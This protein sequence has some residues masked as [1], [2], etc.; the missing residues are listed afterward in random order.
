MRW[1]VEIAIITSS[2]HTTETSFAEQILSQLCQ[3]AG[4]TYIPLQIH[5]S[6]ASD[7]SATQSTICP[8]NP[9]INTDL[10]WAIPHYISPYNY[11]IQSNQTTSTSPCLH[12]KVSKLPIPNQGRIAFTII[13]IQN[14]NTLRPNP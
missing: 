7:Q 10:P 2:S 8:S 5:L 4:K 3:N 13:T 11:N 6:Q 14:S 1:K 9:Y 12:Q